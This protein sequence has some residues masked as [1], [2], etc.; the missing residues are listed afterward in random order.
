M[1]IIVHDDMLGAVVVWNH[2]STCYQNKA[3]VESKRRRENSFTH[4]ID[5]LLGSFLLNCGLR[6]EY[7]PTTLLFRSKHLNILVY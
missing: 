1:Y 2:I 6:P 7:L 5:W 4:K 3:I